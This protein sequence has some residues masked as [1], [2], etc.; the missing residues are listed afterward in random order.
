M[1]RRAETVLAVFLHAVNEYGFPLHIRTDMGTENV[2][3]ADAQLIA[4]GEQGMLVGRSVHN[5]RIERLWKDMKVDAVDEFIRVFEKFKSAGVNFLDDIDCFCMH[6]LFVPLINHELARFAARWNRHK[7]STMRYKSPLQVIMQADYEVSAAH[8]TMEQVDQ[9]AALHVNHHPAEQ[10][11]GM[12]LE[13]I[14]LQ[15]DPLQR[16]VFYEQF[17][18]LSFGEQKRLEMEFD[19]LLQRYVE[20]KALVLAVIG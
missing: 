1:C 16:R 20:T 15:Q 10:V 7:V 17:S 5:Q 12:R 6:L 8:I 9:I 2:L 14:Q 13:P 19:Y 18:P 3:M 4:R 11:F